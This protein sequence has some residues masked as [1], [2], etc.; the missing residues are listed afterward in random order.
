MS[1]RRHKSASLKKQAQN[2]GDYF[3]KKERTLNQLLS[4]SLFRETLLRHGSNT[5]THPEDFMLFVYRADSLI[6]WTANT[7]VLT[8]RQAT[9]SSGGKVIRLKNGY[10]AVNTVTSEDLLFSGLMPVRNDFSIQNDYLKNQFVVPGISGGI[11]QDSV[12][13]SWPVRSLDNR[14]LFYLTPSPRP[15]P[16]QESAAG[17]IVFFLAFFF[18]LLFA[19]RV[20][21]QLRNRWMGLSVIAGTAVVIRLL[22][23][24]LLPPESLSGSSLFNPQLYATPLY[25]L[26]LGDLAVNVSLALWIALYFFRNV[27]FTVRSNSWRKAFLVIAHVITTLLLGL[28]TDIVRT[29]VLDSNISF[30]VRN[31]LSLNLY[32]LFGLVCMG[33]MFISIFLVAFRLNSELTRDE[34]V[35]GV[36]LPLV[37]AGSVIGLGIMGIIGWPAYWPG[38]I[39]AAMVFAVIAS[40]S[41]FRRV[42]L[43]TFNTIIALLAFF[44]LHA[45][46]TIDTY[47][48]QKE[49]GTRNVYAEKLLETNDPVAEYLYSNIREQ[50]RND[51]LIR[52]YFR[53]PVVS[54][55]SV[56]DRITYVYFGPH[57]NRY[58]VSVMLFPAD[59]AAFRQRSQDDLN[60]L[61]RM[62]SETGR[63]A[64]SPDLYHRLT[65]DGSY[66]YWVVI[67]IAGD[68]E[69]SGTLVMHLVP[70]S[71]S[72]A[73]VY[74]ELLLERGVRP[75]DDYEVYEYAVYSHGRMVKHSGSYP[76]RLEDDTARSVGAKW[77]EG[78]RYS[79]LVYTPRQGVTV[80]VSYPLELWIEPVSLF[81]YVF[82]IF[83]L[84]TLVA[85]AVS[86]IR[87]V[88]QLR[89]RAEGLFQLSF[90]S[91]IQLVVTLIIVVSFIVIGSLTVIN[92]TQQYDV[93]HHDRLIRKVRQVLTGLEL[94]YPA[95]SL[96][97]ASIDPRQGGLVE[98]VSNLS[99]THAIDINIYS[100][101]G[102]LIVSSQPAIFDKGLV[103]DLIEPVAWSEM[104][105]Q[106]RS[107]F[108]QTERIGKLKYLSA[109]VPL[110]EDEGRFTE[111]LNLPYFAK[112]KNLRN[113]I[114][115]FLV[116]FIDVYVLLLLVAGLIALVVSNS[117]TR[118]LQAISNKLKQV[119]LGGSNEPITW[120]SKDEIGQLVSEYNKMIREIERSAKLLARSERESAWREM[121]QQVAHEIKNPLTP[122]KLSIQ[123][124][125]RAQRENDPKLTELVQKV[126]ATLIEQ[127]EDLSRI[128]SEFSAFAQMPEARKEPMDLHENLRSL[129]TL[130]E[131]SEVEVSSEIP[132]EPVMILADKGHITRV[133][134]NVIR[135]AMQAI[136]ED[137]IGL[138]EVKSKVAQDTVTVT[139]SDNGV[140]ISAEQA[141]KV[142]AP[143]FTTKT[144]GAGLGLAIAKNIVMLSGGEIDFESVEGVG[145][146]FFV[147]LPRMKKES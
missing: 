43:I 30:D 127:I 17:L 125:Q 144:S 78:E 1:E 137:R 101:A 48:H 13:A 124:L 103:S 71:V 69:L 119:Q 52:S 65:T 63:R 95:D 76:Y 23:F 34:P 66:E 87:R 74:P 93:Y 80:W 130:Y 105:S 141:K 18:V 26:A 121:A 7:V 98:A 126:S 109:Y 49:R 4:D 110:H 116:Y 37:I 138:I 5:S 58:E 86:F 57:L 79:H 16:A 120:R 146:E 3:A 20:A 12:A 46:I 83:L 29:L 147:T 62:L 55:R 84:V 27:H 19:N 142:F 45:A 82:C 112:E 6:S 31:I 94:Q 22:V 28:T 35:L 40:E 106:K 132:S 145:T 75:I 91:K 107:Q 143:N 56:I 41:A 59:S 72:T 136:P 89:F 97:R 44:S 140:G 133:F 102:R 92:I 8:R 21:L 77:I 54:T 73:T 60:R 42:A 135:N 53:N 15:P 131:H 81:S 134:G 36:R 113:E 14:L 100:N 10:Y 64:G 33:V 2:L 117:V 114:S 68:V 61:R 122:M 118:P 51:N 108:I 96:H 9:L 25:A 139:V 128:A 50:L 88:V 70:K 111:I 38:L 47:N 99:V 32:S 67:D 90:R 39:G 123:H 129:L 85:A 24:Y 11:A 115:D 104:Q